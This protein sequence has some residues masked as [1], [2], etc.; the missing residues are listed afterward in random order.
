VAMTGFE[1]FSVK[2]T[3]VMGHVWTFLLAVGII[4]LWLCLGPA[5]SWSDSWQLLVNTGTT[6]V[7]FLMVFVIQQSQNREGLKVQLKLDELVAAVKGASSR[8]IRIEDLSESELR[9]LLKQLQALPM[10]RCSRS[11]EDM[12]ELLEDNRGQKD[13]RS[14]HAGLLHGH[15]P[16][17]PG[18]A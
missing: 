18:T 6:V 17:A 11:I 8:V 14:E 16:D 1:R 5:C 2:V 4:F 13:V 15:G 7:T 12:I 3:E 9:S 10:S